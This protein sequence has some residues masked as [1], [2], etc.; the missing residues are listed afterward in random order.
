IVLIDRLDLEFEAGL[1]VF[2][3]ETG[4]GKSIV[5]DALALALG[6]RGEAGLVREGAKQGS[7]T[8]AF[9]QWRTGDIETLLDTQGIEAAENEL[10]LR[11][12]QYAD[13]RTRAFLNDEPVSVRLL[14]DIGRTLVEIH[15]Q[16]DERALLE[17]ATHLAAVDSFGGHEALLDK[18]SR[19]WNDWS[20]AAQAVDE[21]RAMMA[22]AVEDGEFLRHAHDE[23]TR[24]APEPGEEEQLASERTMMMAGERVAEELVRGDESL[25]G[26][27]GADAKLVEALAALERADALVPG[28]LA[29]GI[30]A[31]MRAQAE[32]AETGRA[33][34]DA[35]LRARSDPERLEEVEERLFALRAVARKHGVA[36]DQLSGLAESIA[37]KLASLESGEERLAELTRVRGEARDKYLERAQNLGAARRKAAGRLD[38]AVLDELAPLKLEQARFETDFETL[39]EDQAGPR[40]VDRAQFTLAANEGTQLGPLNKVA[41]GGEL[42]RVMLALKVVLAGRGGA[43]TLIFDEIDSGVGGAVAD[44][45]GERLQRL[46]GELQVVVVTHSPQV[47]ARAHDHL[48][49]QK[50]GEG[51]QSPRTLVQRLDERAR[52]EEIARMLA[53]STVT[54]EARAAAGRLIGGAAG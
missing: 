2:S 23:L 25:F 10:V 1:S 49:I 26:E 39:P 31:L 14:R 53:G 18:L 36:V 22:R 5:L 52:R 40:G 28:E 15:G 6:G 20:A 47:A 45:V 30:E 50:S 16:H 4:A 27:A 41:S 8:A 29:G 9:S 37:A 12:V 35:R 24:L 17:P 43:P 33:L 21:H 7:V 13:G 46:G 44:A 48:L 11:R 54:E 38:R 32:L 51:V 42:S 3:G 19:C 34:N